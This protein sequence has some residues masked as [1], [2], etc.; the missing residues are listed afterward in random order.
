MTLRKMTVI[1]IPQ[2]I[3]IKMKEIGS[4]LGMR[5]TTFFNVLMISVIKKYLNVEPF[6]LK[7]KNYQNIDMSNK[8]KLFIEQTENW[9]TVRKHAHVMK[10][11][12]SDLLLTMIECELEEYEAKKKLTLEF[13]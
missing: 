5:F 4:V 10:K 9:E 6:P 3:Y 12:A 1:N 8:K 11:H 13:Y 7:I 2:K